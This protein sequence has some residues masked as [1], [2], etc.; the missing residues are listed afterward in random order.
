MSDGVDELSYR[1]LQKLAKE[2]GIRANQKRSSLV[3]EIRA[4]RK[5]HAKSLIDQVLAEGEEEEQEEKQP[6]PWGKRVREPDELPVVHE[7]PEGPGGVSPRGV[8]VR[9]RGT[10]DWDAFEQRKK[11][12]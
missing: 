2:L 6:T 9:G 8:R 10:I 12:K 1:E 11:R 3:E 4:K 7:S 5:P